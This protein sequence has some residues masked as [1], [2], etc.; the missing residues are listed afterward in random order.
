MGKDGAAVSFGDSFP[1][2]RWEAVGR[3]KGT[4][5]LGLEGGVWAVFNFSND[6]DLM[7]ADW[8]ASLPLTYRVDHWT[9][10]GRYYHVSS[11][12]GDEYM[13]R[14]PGVKR[15]NPSFEALEVMAVKDWKSWLRVYGG[16]GRV[17]RSDSTF[18]L[19]PLYF[20]LGAEVRGYARSYPST[21]VLA[22][23]YFAV[24]SSAWETR[25]FH[26]SIN[27]ALGVEWGDFAGYG[28]KVRT[29]VEYYSGYC[30]EGQFG[31]LRTHSLSARLAYGF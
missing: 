14:H 9:F 23:P 7:N 19:Q 10:R 25:H 13:V 5:E 2:K 6:V 4:M 21:R 1:I 26:P 30:L 12:L 3:W 17:L 11:H 24:H 8:T 29:S 20:L 28:R 22:Q 15:L 18:P 27:T 16:L 31:D